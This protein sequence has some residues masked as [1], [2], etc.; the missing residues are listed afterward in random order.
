MMMGH[1]GPLDSQWEKGQVTL[2][3]GRIVPGDLQYDLESNVVVVKVAQQMRAFS[4]HSVRSFTITDE[5]PRKYFAV[6]FQL[7]GGTVQ[8]MFFQLVYD[9]SFTLFVR[10][11]EVYEK[12]LRSAKL[13]MIKRAQKEE[14]DQV[15]ALQYY[16]YMPDG[17]FQEVTTSRRDLSHLLSLNE[18][19]VK[20]LNHYINDEKIDFTRQPDIIQLIYHFLNEG[21]APGRVVSD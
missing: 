14:E 10:E 13:P 15:L 9:G 17:S 20:V 4:S 6:P 3:D 16:A 11:R 2:H 8:P 19:G 7:P 5:M 12:A 21:A 18:D 1:A